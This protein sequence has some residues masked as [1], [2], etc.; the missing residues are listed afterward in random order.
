MKNRLKALAE[1]NWIWSASA[2]VIPFVVCVIIGVINGTYP[3]GDTCILHVDMYH[4]YCP[5]YMELRE[6]ITEGSSLMYSWNIGMGADFIALYAYYLSSP[7][8]LL[9][10]LCPKE[11]VIE[12]MTLATWVKL[13]LAGLFF[14]WFIRERFSLIGKDGKYHVPTVVPALVF[15]TAYAFSGFVAAYSWNI[16]WMDSIALAPLVVMGLEKLV[17]KNQPA[18]YYVALAA[19]ILCNYYISIMLCIFLVL[20]F[21]L[22]FL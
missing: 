8:N 17:K 15:S 2:F 7:M 16:M 3:F 22:L 19:S 21:M 10:V 14:F 9:L 18:W 20:Y 4:Q 5:F 1:K 13:S 6:K 12:F 11:Y